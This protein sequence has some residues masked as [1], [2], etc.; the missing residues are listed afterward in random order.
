MLW[1]SAKELTNGLAS[2]FVN[3]ARRRA[4]RKRIWVL[5]WTKIEAISAALKGGSGILP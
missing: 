3:F 2:G 4:G 1:K 5:N